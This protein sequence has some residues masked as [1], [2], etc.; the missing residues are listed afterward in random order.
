M[1][2][3]RAQRELWSAAI[4]TAMD[5]AWT[6]IDADCVARGHKM[7]AHGYTDNGDCRIEFHTVYAAVDWITE[8]NI[9]PVADV[10]PTEAIASLAGPVVVT[11]NLYDFATANGLR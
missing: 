2:A 11:V 9:R 3:S 5:K 4:I 10:S 1:G 8:R 7:N 6:A